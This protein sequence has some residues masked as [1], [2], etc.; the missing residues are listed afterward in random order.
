MSM[1]TTFAEAILRIEQLERGLDA[2]TEQLETEVAALH[3][4]ITEVHSKALRA[5]TDVLAGAA[6]HD[7]GSTSK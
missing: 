3:E 2:V 6:H 1:P 7:E 5:L 4:R